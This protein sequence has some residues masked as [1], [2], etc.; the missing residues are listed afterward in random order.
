MASASFVE[1]ISHFAGYLR[2]FEDIARDR[3]EYDEAL[4]ARPSDDYT[5]PR[6]DY[7]H[8]FTPDDMDIFA[9]PAPDPIPDDPLQL[10]RFEP[11]NRVLTLPPPEP[12]SFPPSGSPIILLPTASGAGGG[13]GGIRIEHHIKVVYQPGVEQSEIEVRQQ[14]IMFND[15]TM[16][17]AGAGPSRG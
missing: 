17:P 4:V 1:I 7:D 9:G 13:G 8:P 2:I 6:P 15:V 3:I 16:L 12:D 10:A 14:N 11:I 5:T